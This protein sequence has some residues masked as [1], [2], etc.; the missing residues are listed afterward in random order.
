MPVDK[1]SQVYRDGYIAESVRLARKT[2]RAALDAN[3]GMHD[4]ARVV[5]EQ[6]SRDN[7]S[8]QRILARSPYV[9]GSMDAAEVT[10]ASSREL[11]LRELKELGIEDCADNDP[12]ALL[13]AHHA[14]RQFARDGGKRAGMDSA[15]ESAADRLLRRVLGE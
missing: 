13:D 5:G 2:A 3:L 8:R 15:G 1:T 10:T 9:F 11:A 7:A 12:V 14:G 4:I 6:L